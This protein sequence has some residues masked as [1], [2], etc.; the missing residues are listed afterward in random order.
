MSGIKEYLDFVLDKI[1]KRIEK[2]NS[3]LRE[4][5]REIEQMHEYYWENYTE[6]DQYGYENY[7]NQQAVKPGEREPGTAGTAAPFS[8]N[9]GFPFFW[10]CGF[11]V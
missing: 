1:E 10:A 9:A 7:D 8:E 6:M 5:E 3:S 2:I 11:S 4:G